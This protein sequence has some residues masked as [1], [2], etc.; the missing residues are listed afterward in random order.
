MTQPAPKGKAPMSGP[1]VSRPADRH[2]IEASHRAS[3]ALGDAPRTRH[4]STAWWPEPVRRHSDAAALADLGHGGE[5]LATGDRARF[6]SMFGANFSRVRVHR[7]DR[8][9]ALA[10]AF[11]ARAFAYGEHVVLA[12]GV[13]ALS[14]NERAHLLAHELAHV[15]QQRD[16]GIRR[17]DRDPD[18]TVDAV[19]KIEIYLRSRQILVTMTSGKVHRL[20]LKPGATVTPSEKGVPY[21]A[22][23]VKGEP[24]DKIATSTGSWYWTTPEGVQPFDLTASPSASYDL[25]VYQTMADVQEGEGTG[26]TA[27]KGSGSKGSGTGADAPE[28]GAGGD[29]RVRAFGDALKRANVTGT[30]QDSDALRELVE[31]LDTAGIDDFVKFLQESQSAQGGVD[32]EKLAELYA[33]LTPS[34][35]ELMRVNLALQRTG[36][37]PKAELPE[38]IR[39]QLTNSAEATAQVGEQVDK[40]NADLAAIQKKVTPDGIAKKGDLDPIDLAKLPAFNEMMMLQ[41]LLAGAAERS[42]EIESIAKDLMRTIDEVRSYVLEEIAWMAGEIAV[43]SIF[44]ALTSG[45]T[46]GASLALAGVRAAMLLRRL[47]KLRKFLERVERVYS[48][49]QHIEG[50][51]LTVVRA[52]EGYKVFKEQYDR[53]SVEWESLHARLAAAGLGEDEELKL[54]DQLDIV[55]GQ[56]IDELQRQLD[57]GSGLGGLLQHFYIP[58]HAGDDEL[59]RILLDLP[60]GVDA[61]SE[62]AAFYNSGKRGD[63]EFTR[64]LAFKAT[65]AGA[66]LYPFVGFLAMTV[67]NQLSAL[68]AEKDLGDRLLEILGGASRRAKQYKLPT[69]EGSRRRMK[70][71]AKRRKGEPKPEA[72]DEGGKPKAQAKDKGKPK[73]PPTEDKKDGDPPHDEGKKPEASDDDEWRKVVAKVHA[74]KAEFT[75]DGASNDT[76]LTRARA[77]RKQHMRVAGAPKVTEVADRGYW[78]VRIPRK[79][80]SPATAEQDVLMSLRPR[81]QRGQA[82]VER[83]ISGLKPSEVS[84][85]VVGERIAPL[86]ERYAYAALR[87]EKRRDDKQGIAV[88]GQMGK[89]KL[90]DVATLDDVRGLHYG[91]EKDPI[92]VHWYKHV[93]NYRSMLRLRIGSVVEEVPMS[94]ERTI[95]FEGESVRIGVNSSFLIEK[96][97]VIKRHSKNKRSGTK[98]D[99]YRRALKSV[100]FDWGRDL[101]ADHVLDLGFEGKDDYDNLYPLNSDVN[102]HAYTGKWYLDYAIEYRDRANPHQSQMT[103]LYR[104]NGM[105]FK[106]VGFRTG[107]PKGVGGRTDQ[108]TSPDKP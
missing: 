4:A 14:G 98:Q 88:K 86:Q 18:P 80:P 41:G 23:H 94:S 40:L 2:E 93:G 65:R 30:G 76:A 90:R 105:H 29:A 27:G 9:G 53:W 84:V 21:R 107:L 3:A 36:A 24:I 63:L 91:T 32:F 5:P 35:R 68:I 79:G 64:M 20:L 81:W 1:L 50:L 66:L 43:G 19:A 83:A 22:T 45:V 96:G 57:Q 17:V 47:N 25:Y 31:K 97:D 95:D 48:T 103:T 92:P 72:A 71:V 16:A 74:M 28:K 69:R 101:D 49:Y 54:V 55:E 26:T 87:A 11:Q 51:I 70:R 10:G 58:E 56:L 67:T 33:K 62:L 38:E 99:R 8:A 104:A 108:W 7:D 85:A 39:L 13:A 46:G 60:R 100:S 15:M 82:A 106:V 52:A 59:K 89:D 61:M 6:E 75:P 102:R 73:A 42:P 12:P 34:E 44:A 78:K 77:I 37:D